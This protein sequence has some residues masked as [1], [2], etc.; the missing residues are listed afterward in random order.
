MAFEYSVGRYDH[1]GSCLRRWTCHRSQPGHQHHHCGI[2][3]SRR[4]AGHELLNGQR[5]TTP[6]RRNPCLRSPS[7][8]PPSPS[9]ISST[10]VNSWPSE[11]IP[12][13]QPSG[14][15]PTLSSGSPQRPASSRSTPTD[16]VFQAAARTPEL[17][18]LTETAAP[19]L[20]RK[21]RTRQT[22]SIQTS[23]ATFSCPLVLPTPTT[24]GS[25][26]P[27]SQA[28]SLL[29]TLTIYNEGLNTT[30]WLVTGSL[31]HRNAQR[32]PLRPRLQWRW[33][34]RIGLRRN[35]SR[36]HYRTLTAPAGQG[37]FGGWSYNCMPP[38][39]R[40]RG[41]SQH[42]QV[43]LDL[44]RYR[45]RNLQL[46]HN[47]ASCK[48]A[49]LRGGFLVCSRNAPSRSLSPQLRRASADPALQL[50]RLDW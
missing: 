43:T 39:R 6:L 2:E 19:R 11:P 42:C 44:R 48:K 36:R 41:W 47:F 7:F 33:T 50:H 22:G 35:L 23:T 4:F 15:L 16:Q 46:D 21:P 14:T 1:Y 45:R 8:P 37:A 5:H 32:D 34:G 10:L 27:G 29:S 38:G 3:K 24:A 25:C 26:Y 28:S 18:L 9:A 17:S 31:R 40:H 49:A 20:L 30:N 12:L 13:R